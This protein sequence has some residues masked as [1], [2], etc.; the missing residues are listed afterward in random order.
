MWAVERLVEHGP[1][2][3]RELLS[4]VFKDAPQAEAVSRHPL[5]RNHEESRTKPH[6]VV[7]ELGSRSL[8]REFLGYRPLSEALHSGLRRCRA[9]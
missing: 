8:I 5:I 7:T 3:D 4:D 1:F 9:I 6:P 2:W